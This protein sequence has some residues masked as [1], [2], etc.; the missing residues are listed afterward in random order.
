MESISALVH[1]GQSLVVQVT[2]DF[3][4]ENAAA[5]FETHTDVDAKYCEEK[6]AARRAVGNLKHE[7]QK[8]IDKI[9]KL[10]KADEVQVNVGG[11][12]QADVRFA[13]NQMS[14]AGGTV[15]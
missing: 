1:E 12:Y 4:A 2:K 9:K 10:S 15:P 13:A 8:V 5:F 7:Q 14:T 11:G 6:L 3:N